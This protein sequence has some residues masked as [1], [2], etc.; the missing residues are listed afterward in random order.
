MYYLTDFY[1]K[2]EEN[3]ESLPTGLVKV[4]VSGVGENVDGSPAL[5]PGPVGGISPPIVI[6]GTGI[7]IRVPGGGVIVFGFFGLIETT[8]FVGQLPSGGQI[9][10]IGPI[11]TFPL[12]Q[13]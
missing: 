7:A 8:K 6:D 12:S 3:V 1:T 5:A 9:V 4:N 10:V 2:Q 11:F 13:S